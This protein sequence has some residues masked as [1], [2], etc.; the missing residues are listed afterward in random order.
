[1]PTSLTE[2]IYQKWDGFCPCDALGNTQVDTCRDMVDH[3]EEKKHLQGGGCN[4]KLAPLKGPSP[5]CP[6]CSWL[7]VGTL[8][9]G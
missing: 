4:M 7:V 1:M 8:E 2:G 5:F 9:R 6:N 3:R